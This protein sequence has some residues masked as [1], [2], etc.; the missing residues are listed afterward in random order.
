VA[1]QIRQVASARLKY[2]GTSAQKVRL[3]VDLIRGKPVEEALAILRF[4]RKAVAPE[5]G[6]LVDSAIANARQKQQ[7][8]D[9]DQLFVQTACVDGGPALKRIRP[10]PMGRAF[11][12]MKRMSHVTIGLG[13][14]LSAE[15]A[16]RQDGRT[17]GAGRGSAGGGRRPGSGVAPAA[18]ARSK[19]A[20][21]ATRKGAPAKKKTTRSTAAAKKRSRS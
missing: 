9:V 8:I 14:R 12:V 20:A 21:G 4:T 13:Q 18:A 19:K 7:D 16:V 3:V 17:G 5:I 6:A 15:S 2:L 1:V 11:R 10:A